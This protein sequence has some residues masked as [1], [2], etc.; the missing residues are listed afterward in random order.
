M[1]TASVAMGISV[2][3]TIHF[4]FGYRRQRVN[5]L[6]AAR[7]TL[8]TVSHCGLSMWQTTLICGL[9]ML[10]FTLSNFVPTSHFALLMFSMLGLALFAD[11]VI[12]PAMLL[13]G[14]G[15]FVDA[16]KS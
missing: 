10:A 5:G 12:L 7:G 16:R 14:A 4:L 1:M 8:A 15:R 11:L 2:D 6:S 13:S 3:D 9:S